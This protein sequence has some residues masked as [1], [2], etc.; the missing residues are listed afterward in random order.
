MTGSIHTILCVLLSMRA[1][2]VLAFHPGD[3]TSDAALQCVVC[4]ASYYC[5]SGV[6]YNCKPNSLAIAGFAEK[7]E[8]CICNP[9]YQLV[10][11]GLPLTYDFANYCQ[12]CTNRLQSWKAYAASIGATENID[13][14]ENRGAFRAERNAYN[15]FGDFLLNVIRFSL[16]LS[17]QHTKVQVWY[18]SYN[19][20]LNLYIDNVFKQKCNDVRSVGNC[21]YESAY[22]PGQVLHIRDES[23]HGSVFL[24]Y[25]QGAYLKFYFTNPNPTGACDLGLAPHWYLEGK[26]YTCARN[27]GVLQSQS[28]TAEDCVCLRGYYLPYWNSSSP[29]LPCPMGTY[30]DQ[31]NSTQCTPCP[32]NSSHNRTQQTNIS[33]CLCN[34]GWAGVAA[35]G[36]VEC[37]AGSFSPVNGSAACQVCR[38]NSGT[39]DFYPRTE[40]KCHRGFFGIG[41]SPCIE[42]PQHT[43]AD[44]VGS[45]TCKSCKVFLQSPGGATELTAQTSSDS[46]FC[47]PGYLSIVVGGA[48]ACQA[49][50]P[51]TFHVPA[52]NLQNESCQNCSYG[53]YTSVS[54][55]TVC[56]NCPVNSTT[57]VF[58]YTACQCH[59]GYF[60]GLY[61]QLTW[62]QLSY[63]QTGSW[64]FSNYNDNPL[65]N[66]QYDSGQYGTWRNIELVAFWKQFNVV[67]PTPSTQN[68]NPEWSGIFLIVF[69]QLPECLQDFSNH[70]CKLANRNT[71]NWITYTSSGGL[72][73]FK[74]YM[75]YYPVMSIRYTVH[76]QDA[77]PH[78]RTAQADGFQWLQCGS[79]FASIACLPFDGNPNNLF[80]GQRIYPNSLF[81]I[82]KM[83]KQ[84]PAQCPDGTC[85][86]CSVGTFKDYTGPALQCKKCQSGSIS[87]LGS[88]LQS[89]CNCS[90]GYFRN[91]STSCP[92]CAGGYFSVTQ[93]V[94]QCTPCPQHT[95]TDPALHPW[96]NASDCRACKLCNTSTNAAFT[97]HYDAARGGVGCG[98]AS[99][100]LCT[101]CPLASSL[102]LPTTESQRNF[103]VRSCACD[104]DFYGILGTAC[105]ACPSNQVRPFFIYS[106][107]T[108]LDCLC[109]PGFEP[110]SAAANLCRQCPM[111]TYKPFFGDHNCIACPDT[112][113]TE[114][115]GNGNASACVCRPGYVYDGEQC[116]ICPENTHKAGF[117]LNTTCNACTANSFGPA[118]GT[119]PLECSCFQEFEATTDLCI[120]C[121]T[122]K[123]KNESTKI[124]VSNELFIASQIIN[125]ARAC[126]GGACP[127][128]SSGNWGGEPQYHSSKVVDG[129]LSFFNTFQSHEQG[130]PFV[131]V[132]LQQSMYVNRVRIY[133]R[134]QCCQERLKFFE[135]R[136]GNSATLTS[137]PACV[138]NGPNFVDFQDFTCVMRGRYVSLQ[139]IGNAILNFRE[140]EIYGTK[141][142]L[143]GTILGRCSQCP[144][145]TFTNKTGSLACEACAAG[146]TTDGRTGQVECV[147]DVGTFLGANGTCQTCPVSSFKATTTDKYANSG[148][149]TC[150]S[151]GANQQVNTEC[152]N[153]HDITCKAC[154][155]NSSSSAGRKFLDPCFCNAGYQ[156]QG[157]I[158][159]A[160][161]V[162][163]ARQVN[164]NNNIVCE[165]CASGSFTT[166]TATTVCTNCTANC[167]GFGPDKKKI[168]DFTGTYSQT[169]LNRYGGGGSSITAWKAYAASVKGTWSPALNSEGWGGVYGNPENSWVEFPLPLGYL[170]VETDAP[171]FFGM[172]LSIGGVAV[173][174][175]DTRC[176]VIQRY[177]A[178]DKIRFQ[179]F[180]G[181]ITYAIK[182]FVF[183]CV[184][185]NL[186]VSQECN[187]TQD[188][189]CRCCQTCMKGLYDNNTCGVAYGNNRI[190]TQCVSCPENA[191]CPGTLTL[192]K[193]VL[194]SEQRCD[195]NQQV[196]TLCNTTH[197]ITCRACQANSWSYGRTELGP[198][199][200]NAGYE[201]R[202]GLCVA[203]PVGKARQAN[204]NNSIM[205][206]VCATGT[207]TSVSTTV[208]CGTCSPV[209]V[210]ICPE[211]IYDFS[212]VALG[213]PWKDYATAIG[214][215][216]ST[217]FS[218]STCGGGWMGQWNNNAW[219][220]GTLPAAYSFLEVTFYAMCANAGSAI[221]TVVLSIDGVR[222]ATSYGDTVVYQTNYS[223]GQILR[224]Q[225]FSAYQDG[226]I[227]KNLK[228]RLYKPCTLL[229][230]K[231]E[232]NASRDVIC[233]QC[234]K[235]GP[236]F[237]A[238]NTCGANYNNDR[239][240]TQCVPCLAGSYCPTGTGPPIL[241]PDN[242]KSPPGSISEKACDC[243][244]G[245]FR[246]VDGCSLCPF[247]YYCPGKQIQHA[248]A[249]PRDSRTARRGSTS[250]LDC[251]CHTG[252]FRDPPESLNSF[253]CS[254]CL[255]GDFCFNNSAYNCSDALMVSAPGSG[256]FENCT[257]VSGYYNNGTVCEDCPAN[258]YC[259]G[260]KRLP[261]PANEWTAYEGRSNEC[262]C[263]PGFYRDQGVCVPCTDDYFCEGLDDSRQACPQHSTG[264]GASEI[265]HC[266]CNP[267]FEAVHSTNASEPHT[268][269][270]CEHG[271]GTYKYKSGLGNRACSQCTECLPHLHSTWT[272]IACTPTA[273]ALCDYCSV[274]FN[275]TRDETRLLYTTHACQQFFD[276]RCANCTAC[277]RD[278][279]WEFMPC[280]ESGDRQCSRIA[281]DR[282]CPAGFYAGGHTST[283]D[284]KCLPCAVRNTPYEGEWLHHFTSAGSRYDDPY[285]CELTCRAFSRLANATDPS[286]GCTTCETGN[287]LFKEF[288]QK[289]L[290]C[291]FECL[292]GY[293]RRGEDCVLD[294]FHADAQIY[295]NHSVNVTHVRREAMRAHSG[296]S[297]FQLTVSHTAHGTF[298]VVVGKSEPT[299]AGRAAVQL[300]REASAACCFSELWRVSTTSQL[301]L[302]STAREQ[303]SRPGPPWSELLSDTQLV[304][305]VPDTRIEELANCSQFEDGLACDLYVSIVDTLLLHH[306][307]VPVRLELRRAAA[308]SA[309]GAQTYVPLSGFRV[310][311]QLAYVEPDGSP[312][313]VVVSD[314]APL[315]GAGATDVA[316]H[317]AG[318]RLALPPP[319][320]NC[321]RYGTLLAGGASLNVS[322]E[323]WTLGAAPVRAVTFLRAP[324]GTQFLKLFYTLRLREREGAIGT[325]NQMHV[326]VW[327]NLSQV[328]A[329]CDLPPPS[330]SVTG[331][332]VLSCSGLGETAVAAATALHSPAET[333]RGEVGGLTS[334]VARALHPHIRSVLVKNM[335][336]AFTL[337]AAD[338]IVADTN[339]TSMHL[340]HLDFTDAFKAAC[341]TTEFCHFRYVHQGGGMHFL[342]SC[343]ATAQD[344]ARAWLRSA[345]GVLE[346]DGH[347]QALCRLAHRQSAREYA[348]LVALVNTRAYLPRGGQ[349]HDLQNHSA[350]LS[351]SRVAALF[352]F[353]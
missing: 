207:F 121:Q 31:Y 236:G 40:C 118:A 83:L 239:L 1:A 26:Q 107:T 104:M 189:T 205:C 303:C 92:S 349:W 172:G 129:D 4:N 347:V 78:P 125:L 63:G 188:I 197:N 132:D 206:D 34:A 20:Y 5:K 124:G 150:S 160:C 142:E 238:N 286:F 282:T 112:F 321:E 21:Y 220:Q 219:M 308:L 24:G 73:V 81:G 115:T 35:N 138:T 65:L 329:V 102:F 304:F 352:E 147:C 13:V 137:N 173:D 27:R 302:P 2:S 36:C 237:F 201:L 331:G 28:S 271:G 122:G 322:A 298:A 94:L 59:T 9:G 194:C 43:W 58:P 186:Y 60:C 348:F 77:G 317:S 275:E 274:C 93:D 162:G 139:I 300:R 178:G 283:T 54:A 244:P 232:C 318:L 293:A 56:T 135:I 337:P 195:V 297:A 285:S 141:T 281:Q 38:N 55:A 330:L 226:G 258:Y 280:S 42:C 276:T 228:I 289:L 39:Y 66:I 161:P 171:G 342:P 8:E 148:C 234:Q 17:L 245:Y 72:M 268:C 294:T 256:F 233:Q 305:E 29:C 260:G 309:V 340:G 227:G 68:P 191:F 108:L 327:R 99:V 263:M 154:Q 277:D 105:T 16:P 351:T 80:A 144:Q 119:G 301:G 250:R 167:P 278:S 127:T 284:S 165:T 345:L 230:V 100:E 324:Q 341:Q 267:G 120:H 62:E 210:D 22:T 134:A 176:K 18:S 211:I 143:T 153:T 183:N 44:E 346:D 33:A 295:W 292:P 182:L 64:A 312:V 19:G 179:E 306:F 192:Q 353:V 287:V 222:K 185:E 159:V 199:L 290:E 49:C 242:G 187:A 288:T 224:I 37:A 11:S 266:L 30:A 255:P 75:V 133:N 51:G 155:A 52:K 257:C 216:P 313:F 248:I 177:K 334:F 113:T 307:S 88:V 204:Y 71:N 198:C 249:C 261:C 251:H 95:F 53:T 157:E 223:A 243:D 270:A 333:V 279:E 48:R 240:D 32:A 130:N 47:L 117:N 336:V 123:Y 136:I 310:E 229:Y 103:G 319:E 200:C 252:F 111:G 97:D 323:A 253:N 86:A 196:S 152:N 140:F 76:G 110:D 156:L 212:T 332:E 158:C 208:S 209:C 6:R 299:C 166:V 7:E 116:T 149:V 25:W 213:Q 98:E 291:Q 264:R 190:D 50:S 259:E 74:F 91:D 168:V 45:T 169:D 146:K 326:A 46:C 114:K 3:F 164:N 128:S 215:P 15:S 184:T 241:C 106:D 170:F 180:G 14:L 339:V 79:Q 328:R 174:G 131:T 151:C 10:W 87:P 311:A 344:A 202:G 254:L 67:I 214:F 247:D 320:V 23:P 231:N 203:C 181:T 217:M 272:Q 265:E 315:P 316:L 343:D 109:A 296:R 69:N 335:L 57:Y 175:C 84:N 269:R 82:E 235:C 12:S 61:P 273:D 246:D 221:G 90:A 89:Q 325:R 193:P 225:E 314:M 350:P 70:P 85:Q 163:K 101:Q 41:T 262:V 145:N 338:P 96:D 126:S 218:W